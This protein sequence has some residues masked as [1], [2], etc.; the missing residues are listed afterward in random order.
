MKKKNVSFS[1]YISKTL[2][3]LSKIIIRSRV[4]VRQRAKKEAFVKKYLSLSRN[5]KD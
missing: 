4:L 3:S 5:T 1:T 2:A